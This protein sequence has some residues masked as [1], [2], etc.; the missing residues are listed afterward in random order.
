MSTTPPSG[1]VGVHAGKYLTIGLD[2]E[3]YCIAVLRVREII[4]LQAITP[5]PR[6]PDFVK[7]VINLRG[8]VIPVLDLRVKFGLRAELAQR[9]CIVVAQVN[10][11]SGQT[12]P[13]GF[14]V[15]RVEEVVTIAA[16]EIEPT[17]DFGGTVATGCLPAMARV[18]GRVKT[19][20]DLD[21]IVAFDR[22]AEIARSA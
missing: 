12:A 5:V 9:T 14:V 3:D 13:M 1:P 6:V 10:L 21:R 2:S 15:D 17:P 4:R 22:V 8:R 7:G 18:K 11:A 20:L 16:G 19:L